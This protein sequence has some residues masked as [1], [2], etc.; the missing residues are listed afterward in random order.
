MP[1]VQRLVRFAARNHAVF[2]IDHAR[3]LGV[4]DRE[5]QCA[6][7]RGEIDRPHQ[8]VYR[9]V[10]APPDWRSDLLAACWAGGFRAFASHRSAARVRDLPGG[11]H[12]VCEITCPRWRRSKSAERSSLVVHE[13]LGLDV[14]RDVDLVDGLPV[15]SVPLT[16]LGLAAVRPGVTELAL[17][18][19]LRRRLTSLT[20]LD[21]FMTRWNRRGRRGSAQLR[22][23]LAQRDPALRPTGSEMETM[24]FAAVRRHGLP[25][26]R[27][28]VEVRYRGRVVATLDGG[29]PEWK[30]GYEYDSDE[31]HTGR[32]RTASASARRHHVA[33]AGWLVTTVVRADLASGGTLACLA[34]EESLRQRRLRS[35]G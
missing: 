4:T 28:Q 11:R 18:A 2:H 26:P 25:E 5:V 27:R 14:M 13:H 7:E 23:L 34:M 6:Y 21:E 8:G 22:R 31:F 32:V 29:W 15:A 10:A 35:A 9:F 17:E 24:L 19:A 30:V 1:D 3:M 33:A 12:D 20:E 16:L